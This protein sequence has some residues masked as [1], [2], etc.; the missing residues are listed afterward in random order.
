MMGRVP[1]LR[2]AP[3]LAAMLAASGLGCRPSE[4]KVVKVDAKHSVTVLRGGQVKFEKTGETAALV[5]YLTERQPG[6]AKGLEAEAQA[7]FEQL[8]TD[9]DK[10]GQTKAILQAEARPHG[11]I[12]GDKAVF[13]FLFEKQTDGS[14]VR[15][16]P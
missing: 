14:W 4:G 3:L 11:P 7:L 2:F 8:K 16:M 9:I 6:D 13:G 10:T 12:A 1:N 15:K 5:L